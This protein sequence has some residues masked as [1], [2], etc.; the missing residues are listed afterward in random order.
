MFRK[1]SAAAVIVIPILIVIA[2]APVAAQQRV[3]ITYE[4]AVE[5]AL[6]QSA[7]LERAR[8]DVAIARL[9]VS[10]ART[11]FLPDLRASLSGDQSYGRSFS[12]D[13]GTVL[14][15]TNESMSGRLSTSVTLF[16][17]FANVSELEAA[18]LGA[19]ASLFEL[20]RTRQTVVF[21]VIAGFLDLIAAQEQV[22]VL[23]ENHAAQ[24]EQEREVNLL[25]AGGRRPV[26]DLYQQQANV[27]AARVALVEG[28]RTRELARVDLVQALRLD[29]ALDYE[30]VAPELPD[31]IVA[32][33][34]RPFDQLLRQAWESRADIAALQRRVAAA[35]EQIDV[36][37]AGR[38]P[39]LSLS[40]GYGTGFTTANDAAFQ[41]QLDQRR[42]GS[43]GI[44][45]SLPLFDRGAVSRATQLAELQEA[46]ARLALDDLRQTVAIDV[47]RALLD[48]DA[49]V[50]RLAA[51]QARIIAARRALD[52]TRQR[53]DAGVATL[54]EV[55]QSRADLVAA[56]SDLVNARYT[57][58][59]QEEALEYYAGELTPESGIGS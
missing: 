20:E 34:S 50:E 10:S 48:R 32:P 44:G 33:E 6:T 9:S 4:E 39:S 8:T 13:E 36:A 35:D 52:A 54:L 47:R 38:W 56:T 37:R 11:S 19:E 5:L 57:L 40:A 14:N 51:A 22:A 26:S 59:F 7:A 15:E 55:T 24:E 1:M 16:D 30:F 41:E 29:P 12:Q 31:T 27:A 17:G 3:V 23:E 18:S 25:V 28:R 49:A 2:A 53:Y 46:T 21:Q 43:V 42:G 45:I 58:L